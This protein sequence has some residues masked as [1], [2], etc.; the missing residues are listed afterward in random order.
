MRRTLKPPEVAQRGPTPR[1]AAGMRQGRQA[2]STSLPVPVPGTA[3]RH[4]SL[5]TGQQLRV[6]LY[7][8]WQAWGCRCNGISHKKA[9]QVPS[10]A[11]STCGTLQAYQAQLNPFVQFQQKESE[12]SLNRVALH[13]RAILSGSKVLL[14]NRLARIFV[15]VYATLL[16]VFVFALIYY[17]AFRSSGP[18]KI[19]G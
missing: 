2:F 16:H 14:A 11:D 9:P 19:P 4:H 18:A 5:C 17:S 8:Q 13:D 10:L 15:T 6:V 7:A 12:R 1:Q 3:Q